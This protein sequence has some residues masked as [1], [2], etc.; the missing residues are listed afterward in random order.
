MCCH[1]FLQVCPELAQRFQPLRRGLHSFRFCPKHLPPCLLHQHAH[2]FPHAPSGR[3]NH[4]EPGRR[5]FQQRDALAAHDSY[6]FGKAIE[7]LEFKSGEVDALELFGRIHKASGQWLVVSGQQEHLPDWALATDHWPPTFCSA[8]G[9]RLPGS[10]AICGVLPGKRGRRR[11]WP[12]A[13]SSAPRPRQ[14]SGNPPAGPGQGRRT[15]AS[16]WR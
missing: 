4:S 1:E 11:R 12:C 13:R 5:G 6:S 10:P 14:K 7:C 2:H 9:P 8:P 16:Q 3:A 15:G